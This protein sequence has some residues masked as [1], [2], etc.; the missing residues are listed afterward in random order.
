MFLRKLFKRRRGVIEEKRRE[1]FGVS[2]P[3]AD[4]GIEMPEKRLLRKGPRSGA[5]SN[6]EFARRAI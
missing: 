6:F 3:S 4:G 2:S 5:T 1:P